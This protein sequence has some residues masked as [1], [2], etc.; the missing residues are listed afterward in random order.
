[1]G[2]SGT[3][4]RELIQPRFMWLTVLATEF[5][6]VEKQEFN[7]SYLKVSFLIRIE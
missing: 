4:I 1:M 2:N 6:V 3:R 7:F 5:L